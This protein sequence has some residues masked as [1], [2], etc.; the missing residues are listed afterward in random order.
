VALT[1][2]PENEGENQDVSLDTTFTLSLA[3][4]IDMSFSGVVVCNLRFLLI[5]RMN[6]FSYRVILLTVKY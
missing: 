4:H 1:R 6:V 3:G 2:S 5:V